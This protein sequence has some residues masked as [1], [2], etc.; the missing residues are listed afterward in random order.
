MIAKQKAFTQKEVHAMDGNEDSGMQP[1]AQHGERVIVIPGQLVSEERKKAGDH[2]FVRE[3]KMYSDALGIL[4]DAP[5]VVFVVPLSGKYLPRSGDLIIGIIRGEKFALYEVEINSLYS[6][7]LLKR[8][9]PENYRLGAVISA[10]IGRVNEM[11]EADVEFPRMFFGGEVIQVSP[12]KVPRIIGKNGSMLAV[13]KEGTGTN[14]MIGRN[15]YVWMKDG[16]IPLAIKAI[17]KIEREA[18]AHNLTHA[19]EEFLQAHALESGN[20]PKAH[21]KELH[22]KDQPKETGHKKMTLMKGSE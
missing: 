19:M 7:I 8:D 15:G 1:E 4:Y 9:L 16:N 3:G 2:V 21:A 14:F 12:V 5:D 11:N 20:P 17:E 22:G 6:S 10:K 13:L 18:H